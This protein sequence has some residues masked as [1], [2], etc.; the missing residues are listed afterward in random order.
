MTNA[1]LHHETLDAEVRFEDTGSTAFVVYYGESG[2]IDVCYEY[3][4]AMVERYPGG[5]GKARIRR[6]MDE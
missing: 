5:P 4:G 3:H 1:G 2:T 6:L